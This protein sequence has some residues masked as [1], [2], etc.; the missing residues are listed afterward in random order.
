MKNLLNKLKH[1][2]Q[3]TLLAFEY[4]VVF[5]KVAKDMGVELTEE[6]MIKA[7]KMLSN[8]FQNQ[9]STRLAVDMVPNIMS[10]FELDLSK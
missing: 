8:E 5:A 7:E 9:N 10:I 6:L 3:K 4:G 1:D 2:K